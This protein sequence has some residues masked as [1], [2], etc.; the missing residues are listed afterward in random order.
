MAAAT[1]CNLT[2]FLLL[3]LLQDYSHPIK[4]HEADGGLHAAGT[5]VTSVCGRL[6]PRTHLRAEARHAVGPRA[7]LR[8]ALRQQPGGQ[9]VVGR[10]QRAVILQQVARA[11]ALAV[12]QAGGG[13]RWWKG[14][15]VVSGRGWKN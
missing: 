4:Q 6:K 7:T 13:H 10:G 8:Q 14:G 1:R 3:E 9:T 5:G 2:P 15:R 11:A 12:V